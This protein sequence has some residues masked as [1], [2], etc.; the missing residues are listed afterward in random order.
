MN[1][2]GNVIYICPQNK[3]NEGAVHENILIENNLF[4][5]GKSRA[6]NIKNTKNVVIR[7]NIYMEL[8]D[9]DGWA[10]FE[11]VEELSFEDKPSM[12]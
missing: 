9:K 12:D 1:C 2:D 6:Y 8:P 10:K 5:L 7:N 4:Y 3:K 11:N